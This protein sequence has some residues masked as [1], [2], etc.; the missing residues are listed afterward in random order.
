VFPVKTIPFKV[1]FWGCPAGFV[2]FWGIHAERTAKFSDRKN[3]E[4]AE[5]Q[6]VDHLERDATL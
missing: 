3:R 1:V 4:H 2:A 6:R 5:K